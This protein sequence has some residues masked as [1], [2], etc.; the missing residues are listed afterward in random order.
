MFKT[1]AKVEQDQ[2]AWLVKSPSTFGAGEVNS[3]LVDLHWCEWLLRLDRL[4]SI[5]TTAQCMQVETTR[6]YFGHAWAQNR[7][8]GQHQTHV[9]L[10]HCASTCFWFWL[11]VTLVNSTS[12]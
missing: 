6:K 1:Q 12:S 3:V 2:Q 4:F 5:S 7:D 11:Q 8:M 10:Q 9:Q